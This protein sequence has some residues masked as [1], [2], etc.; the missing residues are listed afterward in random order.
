[1]SFHLSHKKTYGIV[2]MIL[3]VVGVVLIYESV[4]KSDTK[5][6]NSNNNNSQLLKQMHNSAEAHAQALINKLQAACQ[7]NPSQCVQLNAQICNN[8]DKLGSAIKPTLDNLCTTFNLS[9]NECDK[10]EQDQIAVYKSKLA[11]YAC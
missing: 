7:Q 8:L 3:I 2:A 9:N 1:M 4:K 10:A 5:K 11:A 6:S